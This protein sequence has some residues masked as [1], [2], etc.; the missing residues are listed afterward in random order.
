VAD[1][2]INEIVNNGNDNT[3]SPR[4][5]WLKIQQLINE[6]RKMLSDGRS[7]REIMEK[8]Q[9]KWS[10]YYNY[11]AKLFHQSGELF[12]RLSEQHRDSLIYH[13]ELLSERLN[14]LYRQAESDLT[15]ITP[16]EGGNNR[17]LYL[18]SGPE[19]NHKYLQ[20]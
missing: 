20:A 15:K 6:M 14:R 7:D 17:A 19:Y 16:L 10:Q 12:E 13:K 18:S 1:P 5:T 11:K 9:I 8:L 3:S 4:K 2:I